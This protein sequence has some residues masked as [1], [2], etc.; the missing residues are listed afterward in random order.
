MYLLDSFGLLTG[1]PP[2]DREPIPGFDLPM[3]RGGQLSSAALR[4]HIVLLNFW[5]SWCAPCRLEMPALD[6]LRRE[7]TDTTFVFLGVNE[8]EDTTAARAFLDEFGFD[9]PVLL[10]R[11]HLRERFHYPGLP[12]TLL[13]DRDGKVVERWIGFAGPEQ[14]QA[15]RALIRAELDRGTGARHGHHGQQT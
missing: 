1:V 7:I 2:A 11:G 3:L 9:F 13:V 5:A 6:S 14:L 4:G 8:E 10:G 12:Y 15:I